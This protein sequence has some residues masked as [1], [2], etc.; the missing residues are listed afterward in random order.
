MIM[1]IFMIL[2]HDHLYD[3]DDHDDNYDHDDHDN[4]DDN[5]DYADHVDYDD[6][7]DYDDCDDHD[8][9]DV[10]TTFWKFH[11]YGYFVIIVSI[12]ELSFCHKL[13]FLNPM[14]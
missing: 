4:L 1:I 14:S 8:D 2:D 12:K 6:N 11:N 5:D 7:D 3:N 13:C 10:K 9:N